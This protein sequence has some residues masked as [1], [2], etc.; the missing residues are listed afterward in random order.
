MIGDLL[1]RWTARVGVAC[2]AARLACDVGR[3]QDVRTQKSARWFWTLGCLSFLLHVIAA[4]HFEHHWNHAAAFEST[5]KRTAEMTGW[6]SGVG[7]YVNEALLLIWAADTFCWWRDLSWPRHR[8]IYWFIQWTF[9][10]LMFQATAVFGP[11]FWIPI[12]ALIMTCL[13]LR[14]FGVRPFA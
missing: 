13:S 6:N 12:V 9:A 2:Y 5:A 4:F 8:R 7:L 3:Q 1:I 11:P 14:A 10:F